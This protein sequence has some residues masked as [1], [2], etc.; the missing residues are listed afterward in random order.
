MQC[1]ARSTMFVCDLGLGFA[2]MRGRMLQGSAP[3]LSLSL[4]VVRGWRLRLLWRVKNRKTA[5]V[6]A[7]LSIGKER[8]P[9]MD[10]LQRK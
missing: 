9:A 4:I 1:R 7:C 10:F 3:S 8:V 6:L 2:G 5:E